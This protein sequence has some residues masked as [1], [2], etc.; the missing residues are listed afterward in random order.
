MSWIPVARKAEIPAGTGK[1]VMAQGK[2]LALFR[3]GE[4][5]FCLDNTCAHRGG[6]LGQGMLEGDLVTCPWHGWQ[7][8]V[9]TGISPWDENTRVKTYAV[10][11]TGEKV[12]VD[13]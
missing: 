6:P 7:Y 5:F 11:V 2:V 9:K 4:E 10:Q 3:V 13:L 1:M 12:F 8:S